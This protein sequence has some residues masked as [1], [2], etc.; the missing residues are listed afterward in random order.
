MEEVP[1]VAEIREDEMTVYIHHVLSKSGRNHAMC[2]QM[3][4]Q[5]TGKSLFSKPHAWAVIE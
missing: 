1:P 3:L 4:S 2:K 5:N